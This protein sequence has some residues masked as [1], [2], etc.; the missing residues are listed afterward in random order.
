MLTRLGFNS[1]WTNLVSQ[2]ISTV[3]YSV[4]QDNDEIGPI[5]HQR[6]LRQGDPLSPYLFILVAEGLSALI[7]KLEDRGS[8]HGISIAKDAP[9]LSHL[10][11]ADDSLIFIKANSQESTVIKETLETYG[12]ASGQIIN[13]NKSAISFSS[14]VG[15]DTRNQVKSILQINKEGMD[16]NYLGLPASMGRN[17]R[18]ILGF[19]K[20]R[21]MKR[22]QCWTNRFLTK[23]GREI[24]LKNVIQAIPLHAMSLFL[25]PK[26]TAKEIERAM[27]SFWWRGET[28]GRRGIN[29]KEWNHL[30]LP[31][32][33]GGLNF[34]NI[35]DFNL[36]LISKQFWRLMQNPTSLVARVYKAKYHPN[37][38][39]LE[40]K[41]GGNPSF[42]WS[43]LMESQ[44][45]I[46]RHSRWRIGDGRSV[47]I[48]GDKWLPSLDNPTVITHP[49]P[50]LENE[51]VSALMLAD[52][53]GWD[54]EA[55][56]EIFVERDVKLILS[57]PLG[58]I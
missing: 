28:R 13:Y 33:K 47:K 55:I 15:S 12:R 31:R 52:N 43:S 5:F 2:C 37:C 18:S 25:L 21:I 51:S 16:G 56:R 1:H 27:N 11:F 3:S 6:G 38:S 19:I 14:N 20:D 54:A 10:F 23:A 50:F 34:R 46:H 40:A 30:T 17:K 22:M 49:F 8:I 35:R 53:S 7:K 41:K 48:W 45:I 32:F 58:L 29:W 9:K 57:I 36:A 39:L 44:E 4:L 24:L 42:I 26:E